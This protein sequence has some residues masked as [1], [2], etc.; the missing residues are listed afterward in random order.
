MRVEQVKARLESY[1]ESIVERREKLAR[2]VSHREEP[3][4]QDF[5]EQAVELENDETMV[6]LEQELHDQLRDVDNALARLDKG[7]YGECAEC[8]DHISAGRLEA[9]PATPL[10]F[11]C[12]E[13]TGR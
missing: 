8:G 12:A 9:L 6:A 1:K 7:G 2:H 10:C 11:D 13:A 4:P 3:L 5:A